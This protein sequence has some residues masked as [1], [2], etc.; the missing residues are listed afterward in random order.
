MSDSAIEKYKTDTLPSFPRS[1]TR[2]TILEYFLSVGNH[3]SIM[4]GLQTGI[5]TI[6]DIDNIDNND[7]Q[8]KEMKKSLIV[9]LRKECQ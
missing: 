9:K 8:L 6:A 2:I 5:I 3:Q 1:Q 7:P 4:S